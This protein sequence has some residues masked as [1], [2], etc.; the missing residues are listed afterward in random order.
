MNLIR[1]HEKCVGFLL[2]KFR[3]FTAELW[4]CPSNYVIAEHSHPNEDI[5]LMFLFGST[6]FYRREDP[7]LNEE[8][9]IPKWY[10]AFRCFSVPAGFSHRFLVGNKPLLFINFAS[11]KAGVTPT[12]ASV[13]FKL[14]NII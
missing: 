12:S 10:H 7:A 8:F 3:Q 1:R 11:W 9:Y 5:E 6:I 2:F 13:D 14:T 4:Y